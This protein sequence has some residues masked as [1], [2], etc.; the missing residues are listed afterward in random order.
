[1]EPAW[2]KVQG[3]KF[4]LS[5]RTYQ[6]PNGGTKKQNVAALQ[7]CSSGGDTQGTVPQCSASCAQQTLPL[8]L[9]VRE[10]S[11]QTQEQETQGQN[12][13]QKSTK[14]LSTPLP[15]RE[16]TGESLYTKGT[17]FYAEFQT[18]IDI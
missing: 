18:L 12:Q 13:G 4:A 14:E 9:P 1:M 10:G 16:G 2:E 3:R 17:A 11:S 6:L 8:P 15:H 7:C 5:S